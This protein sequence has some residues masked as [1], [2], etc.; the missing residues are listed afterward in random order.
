LTWQTELI[1][2]T[3]AQGNLIPLWTV[4]QYD[5]NNPNTKYE[6]TITQAVKET[7]YS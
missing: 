3:D 7:C 4:I 1:Q 2:Q 6:T 5:D